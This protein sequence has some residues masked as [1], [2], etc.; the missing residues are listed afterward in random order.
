MLYH[1]RMLS[2]DGS[3]E[4]AYTFEG[5]PN[6][7]ELTADEVV[8]VFFAHVEKS[9]LQQHVDW[10]IN[11]ILKNKERRV[12]TALGSL[13]PHKNDPP[14]PFLLLISDRG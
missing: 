5:P 11:G 13:I 14:L 4:A 2:A 8:S 9:I 10:E 12:V 6:L 1:A 3:G 7:M